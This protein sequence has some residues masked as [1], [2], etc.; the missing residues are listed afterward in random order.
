MIIGIKVRCDWK[1]WRI[2]SDTML[3]VVES[4]SEPIGG[5]TDINSLWALRAI[6]YIHNIGG[7]TACF[8]RTKFDFILK[9]NNR[10]CIKMDTDLA[11]GSTAGYIPRG[12]TRFGTNQQPM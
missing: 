4:G 6:Q 1:A 9:F 7:V 11:S 5:L 12:R 3:V 8:D 2:I 10:I